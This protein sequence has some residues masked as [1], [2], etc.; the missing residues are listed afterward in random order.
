MTFFGKLI[1]RVLGPSKLA[2]GGRGQLTLSPAKVDTR[3]GDQGRVVF[4]V[5]VPGAGGHPPLVWT[6][7]KADGAAASMVAYV[8]DPA[9]DK[10]VLL[11]FPVEKTTVCQVR[12][13]V[14]GTSRFGEAILVVRPPYTSGT[15]CPEGGLEGALLLGA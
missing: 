9:G 12:A 5:E 8:V 3:F 10:G 1:S 7:R 14:A 2:L 11:A 13:T 4:Q 15:R 6:V